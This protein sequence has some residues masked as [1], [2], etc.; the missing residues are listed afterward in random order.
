MQPM[1]VCLERVSRGNAIDSNLMGPDSKPLVTKGTI[2]IIFMLD[3]HA[4]QHEFIVVQGGDLLLLGN[5][6]LARYNA[7]TSHHSA[8]AAEMVLWS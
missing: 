7:S 3:G 2:D 6:F 8:N 1:P 5:D 4:F